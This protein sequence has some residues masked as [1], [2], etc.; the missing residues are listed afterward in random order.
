[1]FVSVAEQSNIPQPE[2]DMP[3]EE[4]PPDTLMDKLKKYI[5]SIVG[6]SVPGNKSR[7]QT[8]SEKNTEK[9]ENVRHLLL[10]SAVKSAAVVPRTC[11]LCNT[12]HT[13]G[14]AIARIRYCS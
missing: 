10:E 5:A 13:N 7:W 12:D 4:T 6:E 8:R 2:T 9:W 14:A 1:M 3:S 11:Q